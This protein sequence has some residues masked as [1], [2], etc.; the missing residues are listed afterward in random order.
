MS[1]VKDFKLRAEKSGIASFAKGL[2]KRSASVTR[3]STRALHLNELVDPFLQIRRYS[4]KLQVLAATSSKCDKGA[5]KPRQGFTYLANKAFM[6]VQSKCRAL[7]RNKL[8]PQS[9]RSRQLPP[10]RA[11]R[12]WRFVAPRCSPCEARAPRRVATS[13]LGHLTSHP[14]PTHLPSFKT[15]AKSG[16]HHSRAMTQPILPHSHNPSTFVY[17]KPSRDL[18]TEP[19]LASGRRRNPPP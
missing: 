11:S 17:S 15:A 8:P 1:H 13:M 7:S 12:R 16:S 14:D 4:F 3:T 18:R 9:C 10:A 5:C 19:L 2:Q 6:S